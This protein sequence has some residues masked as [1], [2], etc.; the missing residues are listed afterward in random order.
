MTAAPTATTATLR[1]ISELVMLFLLTENV[2][3]R[4]VCRELRALY[5]L[6]GRDVGRV[7]ADFRAGRERPVTTDRVGAGASTRRF[8]VRPGDRVDDRNV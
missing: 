5:R 4:A 6:V 1:P 7:P 3:Y 2:K 8:L